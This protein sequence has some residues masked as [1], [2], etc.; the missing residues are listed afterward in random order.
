MV[1]FR[2][3]GGVEAEDDGTPVELGYPRQ[4]GVL[5]VLLVEAGRAVTV[6]RLLER[7]WGGNPPAKGRD[8]LYNYLSRLRAALAGSGVGV[9][10]RSGGYRL[11]VPVDSVDL[12]RFRT[13]VDRARQGGDDHRSLE[14]FESASLLWRGD[15]LPE[16]DTPWAV[17]LRAGLDEEHLA[18]ELDRCDVAL[19]LGRHAGLLPE[20]AARADD[21]PLRERVAA[22]LVHALYLDGRQAE[23]LAHYQRIRTRLVDDLGTDPGPALQRLHQRVLAAD[24]A[25]AAGPEPRAATPRPPVPRQLPSTQAL[26]TGRV[27]E[28]AELDRALAGA[29]PAGG[30]T[31]SGPVTGV[32]SALGGAGGIGKTWLALAWAHRNADRF[33]DG[34]LFVDLRGFSPTGRPVEPADALR[35][36][37]AVLG[38]EQDRVPHDQQ[39]QAA[40]FRSLVAEKR[41]LVVLDN[42][43][44]VDQVVPLLPGTASCA[45]LVTS[46]SRLHALVARFGARP[47]HLDVLADAEARAALES[48]LG[49]ERV[50]ADGAAVT[51]L[52]GLCGG[53][54]LALGL[55]AA[56]AAAE[57]HLPLEDSVAELR[58]LGLAALDHADDPAASIPAVL[59]WSLR[60]LTDRHRTAFALLGIAPGPDTGLPAVAALTGLPEG[61]ARAVLRALVD[62]SLLDR[63]PG[64]RY[65]MH[66]L[67]R[68]YAA[69]NAQALPE[70]VRRAALDRV[71]DFYLHTAFAADR[72]MDPHRELIPPSPPEPGARPLPL[73]DPDTAMAWLETEHAHLLAAQRTAADSGRHR[74]VW[75]LAW[76]LSAFHQRRGYDHDHQDV[77]RTALDSAVH[78]PDPDALIRVHRYLGEADSR[79][80]RH[81]EAIRQMHRALDLAE[82]H[83]STVQQAATHFELGWAWGQCADDRKA[84]EHARHALHLYRAIGHPVWEAE[85]LNQVGWFAARVGE[86]DTAREH[87]RAALALFRHHEDPAGEAATLDSLGLVDHLSGRHEQAVQH[88]RQA[89]ALFAAQGNTYEVANTLD[90]LG[91]PLAALGR[92]DQARQAW[93]EALALYREQGRNADVDRVRRQLG[94]LAAP[95]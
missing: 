44:T 79:L 65:A 51:E 77:W 4:R 30:A 25:L 48:A 57:P 29:G 19:R 38:V 12:H 67:V 54:P 83:E 21:H 14:L 33:P 86:F 87:C 53:F 91:H 94:D 7:V 22:Q 90:G 59:S 43:A 11:D 82:R 27:A 61:E 35:G 6:D 50:A 75:H 92:F 66:D 5:G 17:E 1:W 2:L 76:V 49:A 55:I 13:L 69:M 31:A 18:A 32:I 9:T 41:M 84:L 62:A 78:L 68:A 42:A 70:P 24:P 15:P 89:R 37:L 8:T 71:V 39:A 28:L 56:R 23:A 85:A 40:L 93:Q 26:F 81:A 34:Q 47:L 10:R 95:S 3:L 20:L 60:R 80:G 72:L 52:I 36:F 16:L 73:P 58:D 63:T 46:R 74:G 45:V 88:Y 64:G